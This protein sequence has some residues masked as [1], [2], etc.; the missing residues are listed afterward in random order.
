MKETIIPAS[1]KI[2]GVK[3]KDFRPQTQDQDKTNQSAY[4]VTGK[5]IGRAHV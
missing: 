5:Q 4:I 3:F 1:Q 2:K